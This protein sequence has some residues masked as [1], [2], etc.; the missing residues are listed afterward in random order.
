M[1][2]CN[3][4]CNSCNTDCLKKCPICHANS[5]KVPIKTALSILKDNSLI[6]ETEDIY[7]CLN[8]KCDVTYFNN[9][10]AYSKDELKVP[11]WFKQELKDMIVCYCY[12]ITLSEIEKVVKEEHI[13]TREGI[14]KYLNKD[15]LE[16]DCIHKNPIGKDC[17]QLFENAILFSRGT[18]E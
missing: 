6:D 13:Y 12:N 9:K 3:G 2:T 1:E 8:K 11:V 7:M 16:K 5:V 10:Y 14:I 4:N 17:E 18:D 15:K